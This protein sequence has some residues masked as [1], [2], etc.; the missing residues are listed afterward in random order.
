MGLQALHGE[1][2]TQSAGTATIFIQS[3]PLT[4]VKDKHQS[5]RSLDPVAS[6]RSLPEATASARGLHFLPPECPFS[7]LS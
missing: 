5:E 7:M 6:F 3:I 4:L 2:K 1:Q